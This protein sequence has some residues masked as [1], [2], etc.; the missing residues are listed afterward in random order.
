M[1]KKYFNIDKMQF[2]QAINLSQLMY[3]L[4]GVDGVR[5]VNDVTMSQNLPGGQQL[6]TYLYDGA[7]GQFSQNGTSGYG[8]KYDFDTADNGLGLIIPSNPLG[9]PA[10][11]ELKNPNNNIQ[12]VVL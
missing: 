2:N 4:M 3:E 6:W 10:V 12:G 5:A 11:F 1:N 9:T 8:Y 7:S